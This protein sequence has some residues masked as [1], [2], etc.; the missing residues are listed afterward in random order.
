MKISFADHRPSGDYAL[1]VPVAGVNA[2][3]ALNLGQE[4]AALAPA[5][6][7][8]RFEGEAGSAAEQFAGEEA[9]RT[10]FVGLGSDSKTAANAE[11]LG[12]TAVSRLLTSGETKAVVDLSGLAA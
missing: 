4:H 12:G 2:S 8:M 9:R 10:L 7:K 5:L 3:K 6:A 1:V 11:K